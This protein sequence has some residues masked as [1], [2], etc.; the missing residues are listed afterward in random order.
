MSSNLSA[1]KFLENLHFPALFR[2]IIYAIIGFGFFWGLLIAGKL[3]VVDIGLEE[4]PSATMQVFAFFSLAYISGVLLST[5]GGF[6]LR[7]VLLIWKL[8]FRKDRAERFQFFLNSFSERTDEIDP[9]SN[10]IYYSEIYSHLSNNQNLYQ[11]NERDIAH[12]IFSRTLL[13]ALLVYSLVISY[14][15]L[16]PAVCILLELCGIKR[17]LSERLNDLARLILQKEKKEKEKINN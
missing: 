12:E 16:L 1:S 6:F 10:V 5:I 8:I 14:L 4:L 13:G 3:R 17:N 15:F 7:Y 11:Q 2:D 9:G